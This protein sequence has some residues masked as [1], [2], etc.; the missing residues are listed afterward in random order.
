MSD[1]FFRFRRELPVAELQSTRVLL[2]GC[3][4]SARAAEDLEIGKPIA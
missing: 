2:S 4:F 1:V 3:R